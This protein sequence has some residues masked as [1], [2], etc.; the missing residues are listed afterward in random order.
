MQGK[1]INTGL[2]QPILSV[3][4]IE[5]VVRKKIKKPHH[6]RKGETSKPTTQKESR[7]QKSLEKEEPLIVN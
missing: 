4:E 5:R 7:L 2:V 6:L 1:N 3:A